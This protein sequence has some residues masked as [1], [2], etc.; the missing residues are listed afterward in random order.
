MSQ[1]LSTIIKGIPL[2]EPLIIAALDK[3]PPQ[4]FSK[5]DFAQAL[6]GAGFDKNLFTVNAKDF[7]DTH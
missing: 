1:T 4:A 3:L 7:T 2:D 5:A 6:T